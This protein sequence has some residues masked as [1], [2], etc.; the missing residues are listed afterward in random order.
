MNRYPHFF[1]PNRAY[2][3]QG[4]KYVP[5]QRYRVMFRAP[6]SVKKGLARLL[7]YKRKAS[8]GGAP[9]R[10]DSQKQYAL[11]GVGHKG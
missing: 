9:A 5:P 6:K 1:S 11:V 8:V 7:P 4:K 10:N 3:S 2:Q